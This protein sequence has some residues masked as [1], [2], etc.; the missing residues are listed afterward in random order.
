M[1]DPQS[2]IQGAK[3]VGVDGLR[4]YAAVL[5]LSKSTDPVRHR[6][7]AA[8]LGI[9]K[10]SVTRLTDTLVHEGLAHRLKR[11]GDQRDC[12]IEL[13]GLARQ[14]LAQ[15]QILEAGEAARAA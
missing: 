15:I 2:L 10:P 14:R 8:G 13:T 11:P 12:W 3:I 1:I 4:A 6:E 7:L 5:F 9:P